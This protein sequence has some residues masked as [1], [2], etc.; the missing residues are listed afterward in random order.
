MARFDRLALINAVGELVGLLGRKSDTAGF[1]SDVVDLVA[2]TIKAD[3]SSIYLHDEIRDELVLRATHG[4]NPEFVGNLTLRQGEGLTGQAFEEG[5]LLTVSRASAAKGFKPIPHLGEEEFE[6]FLAA[7]IRR[8]PV[9]I[10]VMT[11][12]HREPGYFDERDGRA[13]RA[14]TGYLA[15]ALENASLLYELSEE[16][17]ADRPTQ[18][19]VYGGLIEGTALGTGVAIGASIYLERYAADGDERPP[20]DVEEEIRHF[21]ESV[22]ASLRQLEDL[23]RSADDLISDLSALV[24]SA[25]LLM[26]RDSSFTGRMRELIESGKSA[27]AAVRAVVGQFVSKFESMSEPRFQEKALDVRDLGHRLLLNIAG[28]SQGGADYQGRVLIIRELY[29]S[30]LIKLAVQRASGIVLLGGRT[31]HIAILSQSL[32]IPVVATD[33]L[34]LLD[35]PDDTEVIVDGEDGKILLSPNQDVLDAYENRR[36]QTQEEHKP[37]GIDPPV[38]TADGSLVHLLANVNLVKDARA[39]AAV[40]AEGIGLYRSEFP[41]LIRNDFPSQDEQVEVYRRVFEPLGHREITVRALDIGGDKLTTR[42]AHRENNPFLGFRGIR[43]LLHEEQLFREQLRAILEARSD[44]PLQVMFPM[45]G[46]LEEFLASKALLGECVAQVWGAEATP[47]PVGAM[48]ELPS[49][50]ELAPEIAREADFLS[51][52]TNDLTMYILGVDRSNGLVGRLYR[53]DHPALLR[54]VARLVRSVG[55]LRP[56]ITVCGESAWDPYM[57]AFYLGIGI[58]RFS[59]QPHR[60]PT[61]AKAIRKLDLRLCEKEA[62]ALLA[63]ATM[64]E[65]ERRRERW[66]QAHQDG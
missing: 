44:E 25:H 62:E 54:A 50:I 47:P 55:A 20:G 23:Q 65:V 18:G 52:G 60:L 53:R 9:K 3:V 22:S 10:G 49:A 15:Q 35:L 7:P 4:L 43:F 41:F 64:V 13:M 12:Q 24:F 14:V 29:P 21:E 33:E 2:R 26:L 58:T 42:N 27:E 51:L 46:S 30:E 1:L 66:D 56:R 17:K 8:G 6:A 11:L 39:A 36:I 59:M 5:R 61:L 57:V 45:I 63:C 32:G 37:E 28:K 40:G 16:R 19:P 31:S 38:L 48:I 34:N